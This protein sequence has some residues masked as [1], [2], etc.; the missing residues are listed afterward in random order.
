MI[1]DAALFSNNVLAFFSLVWV[2]ANQSS[3]S[4]KGGTTTA[5]ATTNVVHN[6][7]TRAA[8]LPQGT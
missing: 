5:P 7:T 2:V 4:S 3:S 6:I 8:V 1:I